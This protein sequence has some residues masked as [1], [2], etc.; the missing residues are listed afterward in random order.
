MSP[1]ASSAAPWVPAQVSPL[2]LP[3]LPARAASAG[4]R[5]LT[6]AGLSGQGRAG[7][8]SFCLLRGR[9]AASSGP[10]AALTVQSFAPDPLEAFDKGRDGEQVKGGVSVDAP[11]A[12]REAAHPKA[13]E[14]VVAGSRGKLGSLSPGTGL[15]PADRT[16]PGSLCSFPSATC[17]CK[18]QK[19]HES[20]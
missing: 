1:A 18:R 19:K 11:Q 5:G 2:H 10:V 9:R 15:C 17:W 14:E 16:A 7:H 3:L 6:A 8:S 13:T 4:E 12:Q 20:L